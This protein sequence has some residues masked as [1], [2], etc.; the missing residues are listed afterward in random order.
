MLPV[1]PVTVAPTAVL[2]A[3]APPA[4][5]VTPAAGSKHRVRRFVV[6]PLVVAL[7]FVLALLAYETFRPRTGAVL[8]H[9]RQIGNAFVVDV[10]TRW[11]VTPD[12]TAVVF[13]DPDQPDGALGMR[14]V[15][16]KESIT[17]ARKRLAAIDRDLV[18]GYRVLRPAASTTVDG[19]PAFRD[20][21]AG[22]D[23]VVEQWFVQHGKGTFRID[24][25]AR[26]DLADDMR[27]LGTRIIPTFREL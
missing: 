25:F 27:T 22:D 13:A 23:T 6:T 14:V 10:P 20:D 9:A 8:M 12:P 26:P 21:F 19:R 17:D 16:M 4:I 5:E 15:R 7:T 24:L 1:T 18:A 2:D 3:P 11:E